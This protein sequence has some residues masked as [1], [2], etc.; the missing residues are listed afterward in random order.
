VECEACNSVAKG[1]AVI[2]LIVVKFDHILPGF[3]HADEDVAMQELRKPNRRL[4]H[5]L[6]ATAGF[7]Y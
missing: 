3:R 1:G 5:L 6:S 4:H 2:L 7:L